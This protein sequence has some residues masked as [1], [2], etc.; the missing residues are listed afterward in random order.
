VE[1]TYH[2][3]TPKFTQAWGRFPDV[4]NASVYGST[5]GL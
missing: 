2:T 3:I 5:G 1:K 4:R